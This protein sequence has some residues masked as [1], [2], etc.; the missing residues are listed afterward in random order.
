M[1]KRPVSPLVRD[2]ARAGGEE[3]G[4][5]EGTGHAD[6]DATEQRRAVRHRHA[7]DGGRGEVAEGATRPVATKRR[8]A[9]ESIA[10]MQLS[11]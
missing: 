6:E 9:P 11:S 1:R 10:G 7:R 4:Q 5:E 2:Q 8:D 3:L